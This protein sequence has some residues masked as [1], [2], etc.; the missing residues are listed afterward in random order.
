MSSTLQRRDGS[1][2]FLLRA[3][4]KVA[5][6][7]AGADTQGETPDPIPNS[8]VKSLG[9]MVVQVGESRLVPVF[10][11]PGDRKI[12]GL[13]FFLL[14][15]QR[16][17]GFRSPM[18]RWLTGLRLCVSPWEMVCVMCVRTRFY[19]PYDYLIPLSVLRRVPAERPFNRPF[20]VLRRS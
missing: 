4:G 7:F 19:L 1:S 11:R 13:A 16:G 2:K 20:R 8:E 10:E 5:R 17:S 12:T 18:A 9:P 14:C 3:A 6:S 15:R